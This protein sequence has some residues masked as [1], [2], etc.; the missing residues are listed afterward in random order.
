[1]GEVVQ[2]EFPKFSPEETKELRKLAVEY[3]QRGTLPH[4][5]VQYAEA[6]MTQRRERR[7]KMEQ[8]LQELE[9]ILQEKGYKPFN[10]GTVTTL[11]FEGG[12]VKHG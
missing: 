11:V 9:K 4:T 5:A 1:M 6:E 8:S 7:F 10:S 2:T 12:P 3:V